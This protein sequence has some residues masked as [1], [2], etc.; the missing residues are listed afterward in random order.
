MQRLAWLTSYLVI[1][2]SVPLVGASADCSGIP[3]L[4][5]CQGNTLTYCAFDIAVEVNCGVFGKVCGVDTLAGV[6]PYMAC[7]EPGAGNLCAGVQCGGNCGD[8]PSGQNC[9]AYGQCIT[10][11]QCT[12]EFVYY[13]T[14]S[15]ILLIT[16]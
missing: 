2:W 9:N 5:L 13:L 4:G 1:S 14:A 10:P 8:C 16:F 3:L 15:I 7:V 6:L 12:I 11:G